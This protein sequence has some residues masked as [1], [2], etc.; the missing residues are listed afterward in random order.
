[1]QKSPPIQTIA[2]R[3]RTTNGRMCCEKLVDADTAH[4]YQSS[5]RSQVQGIDAASMGG[6][7][8]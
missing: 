6:Y 2:E 1:M 3:E 8:D 4:A 7:L 5:L